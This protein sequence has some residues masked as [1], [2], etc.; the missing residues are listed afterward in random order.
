MRLR[1]LFLVSLLTAISALAQDRDSKPILIAVKV[2]AEGSSNRIPFQAGTDL[3]PNE[4]RKLESLIVAE[5]SKL[6]GV[7]V[8]DLSRPEDLIGMLVVAE[9][10]PDHGAD[11]YVASCTWVLSKHKTDIDEFVSSDVIAERDL[12]SLAESVRLHF[13]AMRLHAVLGTLAK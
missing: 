10:L 6:Q 5:F 13:A 1:Q 11:W 7:Q 12:A 4:L 3:S 9:K 2:Q 8:V